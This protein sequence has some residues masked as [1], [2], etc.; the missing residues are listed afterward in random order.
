VPSSEFLPKGSASEVVA[1]R[2]VEALARGDFGAAHALTAPAF[3]AANSVADIR[4]KF[5]AILNDRAAKLQEIYVLNQ[6]EDWPEKGPGDISWVYVSFLADEDN[7]AIAVIT[8]ETR[9]SLR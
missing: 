8:Q 3:Q 5:E 4:E 1:L 9:L 7:E 2:F 6:I